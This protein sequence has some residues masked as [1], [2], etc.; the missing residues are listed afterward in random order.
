MLAAHSD[1]CL[2]ATQVL[3][4]LRACPWIGGNP[5]QC[6]L[7]EARQLPLADLYALLRSASAAELLD[8]HCACDG[9]ALN[10]RSLA[11]GTVGAAS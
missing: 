10:P 2:R 1:T 9:C 3:G 5:R 4:L 6:A 7:Y 8:I 11:T